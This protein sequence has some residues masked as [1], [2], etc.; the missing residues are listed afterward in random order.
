MGISDASCCTQNSPEEGATPRQAESLE[1]T[2]DPTSRA[3][4]S[5]VLLRPNHT[6][7]VAD[8]HPGPATPR[9]HATSQQ[10]LLFKWPQSLL[11]S[12]SSRGLAT[13]SCPG[14]GGEVSCGEGLPS[15]RQL[16][17]SGVWTVERWLSLLGR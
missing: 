13:S 16:R 4:A 17:Q 2:L 12:K 1:V 14:T 15:W 5:P 6:T 7:L 9:P 10:V 11:A 8:Q 3:S